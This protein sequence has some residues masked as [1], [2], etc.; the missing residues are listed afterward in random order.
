MLQTNTET[1]WREFNQALGQ[2]ISRRVS[3]QQDSEDILQDVFF[4]I[5]NSIHSLRDQDKLPSWVYQITRNTIMDYYRKQRTNVT[6]SESLPGD[7]LPEPTAEQE[8]AACLEPMINQLPDKYQTA[9]RL[10]EFEGLTQKEMGE[11][12]G[13]SFSGAKSRIQRARHELKD[14]LLACCHFEFDR[15]GQMLDYRSRCAQCD[16]ESGPQ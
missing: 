5:H 16:R 4:K 15:T 14:M 9:I 8:L 10:T 3:N 6:L 7:R 2:F 11:K 1:I 13:L 12:L